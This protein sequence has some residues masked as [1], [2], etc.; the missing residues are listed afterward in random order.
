M[1]KLAKP[2][3]IKVITPLHAG[4]GQDL[5]IVDMPIQRERHTGFPKIEA[6]GLKGSIREVF[7]GLKLSDNI[8]NSDKLKDNFK[9]LEEKW[10][11]RKDNSQE[12]KKDKNGKELIKFDQ[13]ISLSFGPK[14]GDAHAGALGFTDA[15]ILLFPVKSM[16]GVFAY[17]TCPSVIERFYKDLG[18]CI[19][20]ESIDMQKYNIETVPS[21]NSVF[22][23]NASPLT[24]K[25]KN[26]VV[27]EEYS[28]SVKSD[29]NTKNLAQFITDKLGLNS[30]V[31]KLVVLSDEDFR[32]FVNLSTEVVTRTCIDPETGTVKGGALFTEEYLPSETI[33]YSLALTTPI[34]NKKD[35]GIFESQNE[36]KLVMDFFENGVPEVMQIGGNATIGKGVVEIKKM[37]AAQN[38]K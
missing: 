33:L 5:G 10:M 29:E 27:L 4:S 20:M 26:I 3:F 34:F 8:V 17:I 6:S 14:D 2:F 23:T 13:A 22:D 21:P 32:D 38:G 9:G 19:K 12:V 24:I 16:K 11:V 28:F 30:V 1:F 15:K 37:E 7:E 36:E 18:I 25:D 35:K 31:E